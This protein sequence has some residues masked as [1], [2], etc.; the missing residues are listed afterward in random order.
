MDLESLIQNP[1]LPALPESL[2]NLLELVESKASITE[3]S[4][5]ISF[6]LT[7]TLRTLELA[8]SAWYKR[9]PRVSDVATAIQTIGI[10]TLYIIIFSSSVTR[11]FQGISSDLVNM[12][13]FWKQSI[14][15][16]VAARMLAEKNDQSAP[17]RLFTAGLLSYIGKLI[18]YTSAPGISQRILKQ[19]KEN[20]TSHYNVEL[21]IL[22][23]SHCDVS[24]ELME[25]WHFPDSLHVP[26]R[27]YMHPLDAPEN[28]RVSAAILYLAHYLQFTY[29]GDFSLTDPLL[30]LDPDITKL[31]N[32][33]ESD[34]PYLAREAQNTVLNTITML[35]L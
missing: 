20:M 17:I 1:V 13:I 5:A 24:A 34:F 32:I 33:E 11:N 8:N 19:S 3:I 26:I 31:L 9:N 28:Y 10:S 29:A 14:R 23:Y 16:G 35:N 25:K 15:M 27:Y 22:G 12:N 2:A 18:L 6:D 30:P 4:E 7:L 21:D